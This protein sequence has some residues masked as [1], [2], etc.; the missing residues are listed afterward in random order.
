MT[1]LKFS[2]IYNTNLMKKS[3]NATKLQFYFISFIF[4]T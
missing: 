4:A 3:K 2:I 1:I